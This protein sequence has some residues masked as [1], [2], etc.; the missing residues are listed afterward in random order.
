MTRGKYVH[1][2]YRRPLHGRVRPGGR[3]LS[4]A[5]ATLSSIGLVCFRHRRALA[6]AELDVDG[7]RHDTGWVHSLDG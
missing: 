3:E 7:N 5:P 6:T 2:A 4:S 1:R